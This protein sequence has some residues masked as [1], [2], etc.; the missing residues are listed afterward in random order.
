MFFFLV[1]FSEISKTKGSPTINNDTSLSAKSVPKTLPVKTVREKNYAFK[2][3]CPFPVLYFYFL[4]VLSFLWI[5]SW[6]GVYWLRLFYG[7]LASV[8]HCYGFVFTAKSFFSSCIR[9]LKKRRLG[10]FS[11]LNSYQPKAGNCVSRRDLPIAFA[12]WSAKRLV[13]VVRAV[14]DLLPYNF[15]D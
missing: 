7:F 9:P 15:R 4:N 3:P 6:Q 1:I 5:T 14:L 12:F 2:K 10:D 8:T 13:A 11:S